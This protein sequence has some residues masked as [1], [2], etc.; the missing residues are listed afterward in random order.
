MQKISANES[1]ANKNSKH[2]GGVLVFIIVIF[3]S[4]FSFSVYGNWERKPITEDEAI[5]INKDRMRLIQKET[6]LEI[7]LGRLEHEIRL[8]INEYNQKL[9]EKICATEKNNLY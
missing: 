4:L 3:I 9:T 2:I 7:D 6:D 5:E 8:K 1:M